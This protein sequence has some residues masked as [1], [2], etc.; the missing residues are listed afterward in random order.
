MTSTMVR[1]IFPLLLLLPLTYSR[2][3]NED[4]VHNR[5]G[6]S[7]EGKGEEM[8]SRRL[9]RFQLGVYW[10]RE[11]GRVNECNYIITVVNCYTFRAAPIEDKFTN[12]FMGSDKEVR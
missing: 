2:E 9:N 3:E 8:H 1:W 11:K 4:T 7:N 6:E 10:G 5:A 12:I